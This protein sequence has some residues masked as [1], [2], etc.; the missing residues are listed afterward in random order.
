[1]MTTPTTK[2]PGE[3]AMPTL[4]DVAQMCLAPER[5]AFDSY[6]DWHSRLYWA[7]KAAIDSHRASA[8]AQAEA[9]LR[10]ELDAVNGRIEAAKKLVNDLIHNIGK[11]DE[12]F[13]SA[14]RKHATIADLNG[15][16]AALVSAQSPPA[17]KPA[18]VA[19]R[20]EWE[21]DGEFYI[22]DNTAGIKTG[23]GELARFVFSFKDYSQRFESGSSGLLISG[24]QKFHTIPEAKAFCESRNEQLM[25][26]RG[27]LPETD[28]EKLANEIAFNEGWQE[29]ISDLLDAMRPFVMLAKVT[30]GRIPTEKLSFANWRC[31][32]KAFDAAIFALHSDAPPKRPLETEIPVAANQPAGQKAEPEFITILRGVASIV[33]KQ[34]EGRYSTESDAVQALELIKILANGFLEKEGAK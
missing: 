32:A 3:T 31:L 15:I 10:G 4:L 21:W 9:K 26:E 2:T 22:A 23:D 6:F 30:S 33:T 24:D 27:L 28:A 14:N 12:S 18:E 13:M 25:R 8:A 20:L 7:A 34:R 16:S 5:D 19:G 11:V 1:M 17:P 29:H